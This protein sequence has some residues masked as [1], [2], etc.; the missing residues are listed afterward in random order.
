MNNEVVVNFDPKPSA[1]KTEPCKLTSKNRTENI[2]RVPSALKGLGLLP[3]C[4]LLPGV[5]LAASLAREVSD[6]CVTSIINTAETDVTVELPCVDLEDLD[7][8]ERAL[9]LTFTAVAGSNCRL[10]RLCNQLRLEHL[11]SEE[12][13]SLIAIYEEYNNI[14]HLPGD[15]SKCT[16]SIEHAIPTPTADTHRAVGV[17]PY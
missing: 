15:K 13:A 11:N 5:Y 2:V 14:F 12:R 7:S 1:V 6:G 8:S 17:K 3:K 4:E 16:S 10:S 9:T